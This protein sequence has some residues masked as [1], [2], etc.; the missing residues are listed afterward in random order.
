MSFEGLITCMPRA[1]SE[2][3]GAESAFFFCDHPKET[4][5]LIQGVSGTSPYLKSL[6][7]Q[8]R[9]W[10]NSALFDPDNVM[11]DITQ[12]LCNE[13]NIAVALRRAKRRMALWVA[14]CDL[15]GLWTLDQVMQ[16]LTNFAD[17]AVAHALRSA[18]HHQVE[19]GKP[20]GFG[21]NEDPDNASIFILAMG[22]MGAG[23]LNYSSDI[24]LIC[25]FDDSHFDPADFHEARNFFIKTTREMSSMLNDITSDGYVFRTD[26]RLRPDPSVTP[27]CI[28][29]DAAERYYE[30]LGRTWE[31]AAYIKARVAAGDMVAGSDF[32]SRIEPFVWRKHLDFAAIEDAHNMRLAIRDH[33]GLGGSVTLEGHDLKLGSGGIREIEFFT[34]TRQLISGGRDPSL[35][36]RQT[37]RGLSKLTEKNW[38]TK[39][40]A[41]ALTKHYRAYRRIEHRLQMMYDTQTHIIPTS[42]EG[43]VRLSCLMDQDVEE[44]RA[45]LLSRL[46]EVHELTEGFFA[47]PSVV[48]DKTEKEE[49]FDTIVAGWSNYPALKSARALKIFERLKPE[50]LKRIK[51]AGKH[52][53]AIIAFDGFLAGLPTGVQLFSMFEAFPKLIDLL[54]DIVATSPALANYLSRNSQ[55]FDAVIGGSF[56]DKWPGQKNLASDLSARL[57]ASSN[58]EAKLDAARRWRKEWHFR[59]GVHV[60]RGLVGAVVAGRQYAD[61]AE[62][63]IKGIWPEVIAQFS[64]KHGHPPGRGAVVLG[65]GSIG[66]RRLHSESDLDLIVI[67]DAENA[68]SSSG[69]RPLPARQYY[70]RLTQALVTAI[71]A[72]MAEGRLYEVDMRLRPS[73]NKGP[74]ATSWSSFQSYQKKDAWVW[75]HLALSRARV[76]AGPKGLAMDVENFRVNLMGNTS[77]DLAKTALA[78]MRL[79][80]ARA[81]GRG[82]VWDAKDG[83]GRLHDIEMM[84][85]L[86]RLLEGGV[87]RDVVSGLNASIS[88]GILSEL[89]GR[90]F[91]N[92]Y[93]LFWTLRV[94]LKLLGQSDFELSDTA[95]SSKNFLLS[96][97][98]Y[99]E[100]ES[101][102]EDLFT[103]SSTISA[104]LNRTLPT[105][106]EKYEEG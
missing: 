32:L 24:D 63:V 82:L 27:I 37:V 91:R 49:G 104:I 95:A 34:Q 26:L 13:T 87:Q 46:K 98:G 5:S 78:K 28:G 67:Y 84:A 60:L 81:R 53:E 59:I 6:I 3:L 42:Q 7:D 11:A 35:R 71:S 73:G 47:G 77:P 18:F 38:I 96:Q 16:S 17:I 74:V 51:A 48:P 15:G 45:D 54:I 19:R 62:A 101:L 33:K 9:T 22:K 61:L 20:K 39:E 89:E 106:E 29:T 12:N 90:E 83:A 21:L 40:T 64:A 30:S 102:K 52:Q 1:F 4:R 43:F 105:V 68:E 88:S 23:E 85:Q 86:G 79:R 80:I 100:L 69:H 97:T 14:L 65:M 66:L 36:E 50:L 103:K 2:A 99:K 55:V 93:R 92:A 8:E 31:R 58:Y 75:E 57:V 41:A 94:A 10:L 25:L 70:A 72:Q 56:W 76:I 44:L